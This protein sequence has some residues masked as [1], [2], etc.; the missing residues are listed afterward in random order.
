M[1]QGH[2]RLAA[3]WDIREDDGQG[4][5]A[6]ELAKWEQERRLRRA[7]SVSRGQRKRGDPPALDLSLGGEAQMEHQRDGLPAPARATQPRAQDEDLL[8]LCAE[9]RQATLQARDQPP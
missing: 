7:S 2:G 3:G 8:N 4:A 5:G 6:R 9:Q 1:A